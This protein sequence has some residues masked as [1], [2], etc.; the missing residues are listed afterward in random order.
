[1]KKILLAL[2]LFPMIVFAQTDPTGLEAYTYPLIDLTPNPPTTVVATAGNDA[3]TLTWVAPLN[4]IGATDSDIRNY[5]IW[6][7]LS[8]GS[9][10]SA[11]L[12][13]VSN[14]LLTYT[15]SS[16]GHSTSYQYTIVAV[17][18]AN[19]SSIRPT[20]TIATT[21]LDA[22]PPAV[23]SVS[24][25]PNNRIDGVGGTISVSWSAIASLSDFNSYLICR[26][27]SAN[28]TSVIGT[29]TNIGTTSY[30][31]ATALENTTYYYR[32]VVR[33]VA[34]QLGPY[35]ASVPTSTSWIS[36]TTPPSISSATTATTFITG[37]TITITGTNFGS[38][39]GTIYIGNNAS[40]SSA[41]Y[42]LVQTVG[43]TWT[44]TGTTFTLNQ[45]TFT[46]GETAY[47]YVI[48]SSGVASVGYPV[49]IGTVVSTTPSIT[50]VSPVVGGMTDGNLISISGYSF[51]S[52]GRTPLKFDKFE[53]K[54]LNSYLN[55]QDPSW[56]IYGTLGAFYTD[57]TKH[58]GS[59]SAGDGRE[60]NNGMMTNYFNFTPSNEVYTSYWFTTANADITVGQTPG[61][62]GINKLCRIGSTTSATRN[63]QYTGPGVTVL[64]TM[65][66][67]GLV[68][69]DLNGDNIFETPCY[70]PGIL[71]SSAPFLG[72]HYNTSADATNAGYLSNV[73]WNTWCRIETYSKLSSPAGTANGEVYAAVTVP[74]G[75]NTSSRSVV[76]Q[77]GIV[78][79]DAAY[80]GVQLCSVL[81]GLMV[82]NT[83]SPWQ[84]YIDDIYIN[85]TQARVE[86]GDSATYSSCTHLE[87]QPVLSWSTGGNSI[88]FTLNK[89]T[90][91]AGT[92]WIFII[93]SDGVASTGYPVTIQ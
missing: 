12:D 63:P 33:D 83:C 55:A 21:G 69:A 80:S 92:A 60:D 40:Y 37:S 18:A 28:P 49:T 74:T 1:M 30:S 61:D 70:G 65:G 78:N 6:R 67:G 68:A 89:G 54:P 73:P 46:N 77:T 87:V 36:I 57:T 85:N 62:G 4:V 35:T 44:A 51:G 52:T 91:S 72:Y 11:P 66:A 10:G 24:I 53:G 42:S 22:L 71:S 47:I 29:I 25:T 26:G 34:Q 3:I 16:V 86:L 58:S 9:Y 81:L 90:F 14:F 84:V 7:K 38:T 93:N 23:S 59:M 43:A 64:S 32:V 39:R 50:A 56:L 31:D 15:D 2:L 13:S 8:S 88:Q 48:N 75:P 17:D 76:R 19:H 41:T 79:L 20:D 45:G 82:T 27:T 5:R